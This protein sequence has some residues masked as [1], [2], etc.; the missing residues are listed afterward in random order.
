MAKPRIFISSTFYDLRYVRED[1]E[2]FVKELGYE[3]VRH[4]T[5]AIPYGKEEAPEEYAYREV[6]LS[7]VIVSIIGGRFGSTSQQDDNSSISQRELR[8]ALERGIQVFIF[9]EK[10]VLAEYSTYQLNKN[11]E[12]IKYRFADDV[13]I[14]EFIETLYAL[15]RNNPIASFETSADI[16]EYL[17]VQWA[18][19]FQRFL[20]EQK[21]ISELKVLE[22]MKVIATTL[23]N[24]TKFLTEERQN[25]DE[26]IRN[27][28]FANHPAFRRFAEVTNT[29]YRVFFTNERELDAWIRARGWSP[30]GQEVL[31]DDSVMEWTHANREGYLKLDYKIFDEEGRLKVYNDD[32]WNDNWL[33]F[34]PQGS[35]TE[36]LEEL[37]F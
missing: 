34:V 27:I 13:R 8:R 29:S 35:S 30:I 2:R 33:Y 24:L 5:G 19:L 36:S 37:P 12:Q 17:L 25:K 23:Q 6:D 9:V 31:D 16:T 14:Y 7:D 15:P 4:E 32:D 20:Q 26:A 22:E 11:S 1:L 21:R 28:L 3:P 18:G 10:N